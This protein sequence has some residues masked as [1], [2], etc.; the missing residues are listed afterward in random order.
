MKTLA[1]I[2]SLG[3]ALLLSGCA[4]TPP[5]VL[6]R[7]GPSPESGEAASTEGT[8]TVFSAKSRMINL[9]DPDTVLHT[10]YTILS[11]DGT[12]IRRVANQVS[13]VLDIPAA[14]PLPSGLYT[15]QANAEGHGVVH[16]PVV[17]K[18]QKATTLHLD[19][20]STRPRHDVVTSKLVLLPGGEVVG[21][22]AD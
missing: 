14:V 4:S 9:S 6:D 12:V 8:L 7:V 20:D 3:V 16:I 17:I 5:L 10:D 22:R 1:G 19:G 13:T 2:S 18:P 11:S 21:W 15:I